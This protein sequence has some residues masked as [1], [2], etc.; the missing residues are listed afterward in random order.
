MERR[1][2]VR[3]RIGSALE[4]DIDLEIDQTVVAA[5]PIFSQA[6][7]SKVD[8]GIPKVP[9]LRSFIFQTS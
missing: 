4:A 3:V 5:V 7:G 1:I 6:S 9:V 8:S 2:N